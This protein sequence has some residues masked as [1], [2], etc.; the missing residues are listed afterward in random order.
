MEDYV[1]RLRERLLPLAKHWLLSSQLS[2][3]FVALCYQGAKAGL[4][5]RDPNRLIEL[6]RERMPTILTDE[7]FDFYSRH[8]IDGVPDLQVEEKVRQAA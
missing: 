1:A 4:V 2:I 6:V 5:Q 8:A 7:Y 3:D